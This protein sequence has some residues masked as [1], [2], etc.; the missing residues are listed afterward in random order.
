MFNKKLVSFI[1][2]MCANMYF[3]LVNNTEKS[4]IFSE[5]SEYTFLFQIK[6]YVFKFHFTRFF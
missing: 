6:R 5:N 1:N 4:S 3:A 2:D